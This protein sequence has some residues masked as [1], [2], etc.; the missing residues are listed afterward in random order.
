MGQAENGAALNGL[1]QELHEA[2][3]YLSGQVPNPIGWPGVEAKEALL[4]QGISSKCHIVSL[5]YM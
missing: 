1:T 5:R 2:G 4:K 3:F